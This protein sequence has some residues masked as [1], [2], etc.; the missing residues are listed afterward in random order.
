MSVPTE[1]FTSPFPTPPA[2]AFVAEFLRELGQ[3]DDPAGAL[4]AEGSGSWVVRR[5]A[6]GYGVFRY[7]EIPAHGDVPRAVFRELETARV[8]AAV[9]P[10]TTS[11][12]PFEL[13]DERLPDGSFEIVRSGEPCGRVAIFDEVFLTALNFAQ[14]LMERPEA[15]A[16][17]LLAA[18]PTALEIVGRCLARTAIQNH[19]RAMAVPPAA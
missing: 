5:V 14:D 2:N 18:G 17:V 6:G 7:W 19:E 11:I 13:G 9:I 10:T 8:A 1:A 4:S 3:R 15:L 12:G 16:Q